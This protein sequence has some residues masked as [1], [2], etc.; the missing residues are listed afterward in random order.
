MADL[1]CHTLFFS[2]HYCVHNIFSPVTF[3]SFFLFPHRDSVGF[4]SWEC[5]IL[6]EWV[7]AY[8]GDLKEFV[9]QLS[10]L[11][12]PSDSLVGRSRLWSN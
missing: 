12:A 10:R 9:N 3:V 8:P 11:L 6:A 1:R 2:L 7:V 4:S 5:S